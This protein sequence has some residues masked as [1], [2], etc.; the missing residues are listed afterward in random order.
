MMFTNNNIYTYL[1]KIWFQNRRSKFKKQVKQMNIGHDQKPMTMPNGRPQT[2]D[3]NGVSLGQ[4][5]EMMGNG[6]YYNQLNSTV[7]FTHVYWN[8]EN[9]YSNQPA[10]QPYHSFQHMQE[11][12]A[13]LLTHSQQVNFK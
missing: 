1:V 4:P 9:S 6:E 8:S 3:V 12:D 11:W 7:P 5:P 2:T 10:I 13:C